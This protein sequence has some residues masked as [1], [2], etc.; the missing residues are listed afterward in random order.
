MKNVVLC[1]LQNADKLV[2]SRAVVVG[3]SYRC[4]FLDVIEGVGGVSGSKLI[5]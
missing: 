5:K 4:L 2:S 1:F 3:G